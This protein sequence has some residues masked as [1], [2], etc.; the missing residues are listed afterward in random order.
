MRAFLCLILCCLTTPLYAEFGE[1]PSRAAEWLMDEQVGLGCEG[2][3]GRFE[4]GFFETDLDGD[5]RNDLVL[6]HE[7]ITCNAAPS[8]SLFCGAQACSVLIYL[9]RG[10]LL[11]KVDEALGMQ[12]QVSDDARPVIRMFGHGGTPHAIA[13]TGTGFAEIGQ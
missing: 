9:R 8:R 12:V 6:S 1:R 7:G 13:W 5:G 4:G 11:Q 3:G 2:R 10:K